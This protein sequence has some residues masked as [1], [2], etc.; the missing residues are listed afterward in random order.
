MQPP[1][2]SVLSGLL[3]LL[4]LLPL[5]KRPEWWIRGLDFPRF[6]LAV[7]GLVLLA[8]GAFTLDWH[9][10]GTWAAGL[11][12]LGCMVFHAWWIFPYTPFHRKEVKSAPRTPPDRR[13]RLMAANVLMTNRRAVDLR[14]LVRRHRPDVLITLETNRW[15]EQQLAPLERDY[16]H[17]LKCPLENLYGM[18]LY[19]R[20]PLEDARVQFLV[21]DSV[22]SIH[23]LV[24]LRC[25]Q[26]VRLHCLHPAPPS[27]TEN[28]T[29]RERDAEL[30]MVGKAVAGAS[31]PVVVTGDLNDVAWSDTTR[32]FR[33]ISGLL[34]PRIGRGRFNTYH[35]RHAF[36]RWPVDHFFHSAHFTCVELKR[37]P[38]F[39]SDHF[40]VLVD[41]AFGEPHQTSELAADSEDE[42]EARDK[43]REQAATETEVHRPGESSASGR[44]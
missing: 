28:P 39:G 3:L 38:A 32:L 14:A 6:Q 9:H 21:E 36:L 19:S 23:T 29:S 27:P 44:R 35:A 37:L 11:V 34:D 1:L 18:H 26:A 7:L 25:G 40:P 33:K 13:L 17:T 42:H 24:I 41:L 10:P 20:L 16:P 22:P 30:V 43:M 12:V 5:S 8:V 4:T 2:F 31:L 15:W